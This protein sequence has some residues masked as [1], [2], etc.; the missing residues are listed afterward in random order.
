MYRNFENK[1]KNYLKT[2]GLI[3]FTIF[4]IINILAYLNI[5]NLFIDICSH[6]RLQYLLT[7]IIFL[8]IFIYVGARDK[9]F[10]ILICLTIFLTLFNTYGIRHYFGHP[11]YSYNSEQSIKIGLFNV[12]TQNTN[13]NKLLEQIK[14]NDPDIVILQEVNDEWL[15]QLKLIKSNY[16]YYIENSRDDNFGIALYSKIPLKTSQIE[17]WTAAEVPVIHAVLTD[18]IELYGVHTLP[19]V[20]KDYFNTRN[21]MLKK[22]NDISQ[23]SNNGVIICGDLN[24][25]IYSLAYKRFISSKNLKDSQM[26]AKNISGTWNTRF[27]PLLRIPLE[28]IL[29][30]TNFNLKDFYIGKD[31]GSDHLPVFATICP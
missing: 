8:V 21:E 19:P 26:N 3:F 27:L 28:H 5:S 2:R 23:T 25:T 6:F 20:T 18:N 31:F 22:L 14:L 24:T 1:I 7:S 4:V 29:Y 13:Y 15:E 10:I 12:L 11:E 17:Y 16:P 9:K 30:S